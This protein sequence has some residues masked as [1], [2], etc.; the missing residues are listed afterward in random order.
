[1]GIWCPSRDGVKD[2][3]TL[4]PKVQMRRGQR[5][6]RDDADVA[7]ELTI[8]TNE[9]SHITNGLHDPN[10]AGMVLEFLDKEAVVR[11][12]NVPDRHISLS[13][14]QEG[15]LGAAFKRANIRRCNRGASIEHS[16]FDHIEENALRV[17][18]SKS[19][20]R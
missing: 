1:M 17:K 16:I 10:R 2:Q 13:R 11:W 18:Q 8:I 14:S 19:C 7:V 4:V 9:R 15:E 20:V 6:A 3:E 12:Q 5:M